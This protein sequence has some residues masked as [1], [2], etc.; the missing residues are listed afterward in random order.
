MAGGVSR[1]G[2]VSAPSTLAVDVAAEA[3]LTPVGFL[4]G[5]SMNVYAAELRVAA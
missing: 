4:R 1:A 5:G 3:G 2:R